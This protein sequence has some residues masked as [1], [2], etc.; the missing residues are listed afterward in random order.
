MVNVMLR[1]D[2]CRIKLIFRKYRTTII[3]CPK[4]SGFAPLSTKMDPESPR[5]F[6]ANPTQRDTPVRFSGV[7]QVS[8]T[9]AH[10][11]WT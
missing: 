3:P 7:T 6:H 2:L 1:G 9:A 5:P 4:V 10:L 8:N 11:D